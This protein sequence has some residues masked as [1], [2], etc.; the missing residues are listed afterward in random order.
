MGSR[1]AVGGSGRSGGLDDLEGATAA[2]VCAGLQRLGFLAADAFRLNE[3]EGGQVAVLIPINPGL[4]ETGN[5]DDV[6]GHG[7]ISGGG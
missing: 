1:Q 4:L 2:D 3:C 7:V 6:E 5:S